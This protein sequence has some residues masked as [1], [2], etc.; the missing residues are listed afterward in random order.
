MCGVLVDDKANGGWF[1][2]FWELMLLYV[3]GVGFKNTYS[4]SGKWNISKV[5]PRLFGWI[6]KSNKTAIS[7][8]SLQVIIAVSQPGKLRSNPKEK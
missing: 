6:Y 1:L 7:E 3:M 4:A 5:V 8:F 2:Y